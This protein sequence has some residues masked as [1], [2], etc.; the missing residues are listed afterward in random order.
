MG[1]VF[2]CDTNIRRD[3]DFTKSTYQQYYLKDK[4]TLKIAYMA[5]PI[6]ISPNT[7]SINWLKGVFFI[8]GLLLIV[9]QRY[10]GYSVLPNKLI[11]K[12]GELLFPL[13]D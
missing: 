10:G 7:I 12:E 8:W 4:L 13:L 9:I 3:I 1:V 6:H 11:N 2:N 5:L